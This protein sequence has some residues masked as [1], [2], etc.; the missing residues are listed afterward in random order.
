[1]QVRK[2]GL[3]V[4][5]GQRLHAL[6]VLVGEVLELLLRVRLA[7]VLVLGRLRRLLDAG[8]L[9][10]E[11]DLGALDVEVFRVRGTPAARGE[12]LLDSETMSV[13]FSQPR[14]SCFLLFIGKG[15]GGM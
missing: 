3:R 2:D 12:F 13:N 10:D 15:N 9:A 5:L 7:L 6:L 14:L 4:V 8:R 1:M 11:Q